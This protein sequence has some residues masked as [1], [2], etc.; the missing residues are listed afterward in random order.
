MPPA[1]PARAGSKR[2]AASR[3]SNEGDHP[4]MCEEQEPRLPTPHSPS[5]EFQHES[6]EGVIT[7]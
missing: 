7:A 4:R 1:I 3:P 5:K 2:A 6:L